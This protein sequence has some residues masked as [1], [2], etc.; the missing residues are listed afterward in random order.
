MCCSKLETMVAV[1][2]P[3]ELLYD[4]KRLPS[5]MFRSVVEKHAYAANG[6]AFSGIVK[7][8]DSKKTLK[9]LQEGNYF[10]EKELPDEVS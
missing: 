2:P 5:E 7:F 10:P 3:S 8:P 4:S 6:G 9:L 1:Y